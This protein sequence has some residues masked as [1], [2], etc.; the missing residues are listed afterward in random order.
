LILE[1]GGY[2]VIFA[3]VCGKIVAGAPCGIIYFQFVL[4]V[5]KFF[6]CTGPGPDVIPLIFYWNV[7][8]PA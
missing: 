6:G 1:G 7:L 5:D 8:C 3:G 2:V 4:K